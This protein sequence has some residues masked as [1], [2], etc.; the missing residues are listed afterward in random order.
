MARGPH[1]Y[2]VYYQY[3]QEAHEA[4]CAPYPGGSCT[5]LGDA[6]HAAE[7][8]VERRN[9]KILRDIEECDCCQENY[10]E[11]DRRSCEL[12]HEDDVDCD[13][14]QPMEKISNKDVERY[15]KKGEWGRIGLSSEST[16]VLHAWF[17]AAI[18]EEAPMVLVV[19]HTATA[20]VCSNFELMSSDSE[21]DGEAEGG[22]AVSTSSSSLLSSPESFSSSSSESDSDDEPPPAKKPKAGPVLR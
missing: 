9:A 13:H 5:A 17:T 1:Y 3:S 12:P 14:K 4:G 20:G 8:L 16:L 18:D 7:Q 22:K 6:V 21:D 10:C 19:R 11:C 2:M 15:E